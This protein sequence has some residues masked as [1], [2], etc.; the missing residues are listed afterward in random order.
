MTRL[1][2]ATVLIALATTACGSTTTAEPTGTAQQLFDRRAQDV[3]TAW[4][5]GDLIERWS[6]SFVPAEPLTREPDWSA[7]ENLKM[8]FYGG[9][10]RTATPLSDNPGMGEVTY[11]D[12]GTKVPVRTVGAQTAYEAMV[13]PRTGAC[14]PA[15]GV[16]NDCDWVTVTAVRTTTIAVQTG[17]GP[18]TVPAWAFAV[19]GITEPLLRVSVVNA[20]EV[21]DF[22]PAIGP[23][24]TDGRRLLLT[25]QDLPAQTATRLTVALG[26]GDCD[27]E[28]RPHVLE[29]DRV[30]VV[31]GTALGPEP[32]QVCNAM[33]R[34]HELVLDLE[35]PVGVRPVLDA[36]SGRPLLARV[37]P[38]S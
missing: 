23:A 6:R 3:V 15:G 11:A 19:E 33:L 20:A 17:R 27:T 34:I 30:I 18:A 10:V 29:T 5:E 4:T 24:P 8:A 37:Q 21:G 22:E 25:G 7:R 32:D 31:G 12:D 28:V 16:A 26:S 35:R 38:A 14:P 2:A 9:W 13:N 1:A 36:A